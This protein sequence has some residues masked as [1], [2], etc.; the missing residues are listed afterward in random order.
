MNSQKE[1]A[2][3]AERL[4][5]VGGRRYK[6]RDLLVY[7]SALIEGLV[8][9]IVNNDDDVYVIHLHLDELFELT[10]ALALHLNEIGL[11]EEENG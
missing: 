4:I 10:E 7:D 3:L 2:A 1:Q 11:P 5:Y 6:E 9:S 8:F